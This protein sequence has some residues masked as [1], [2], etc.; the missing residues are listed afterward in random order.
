MLE[1]AA[2]GTIVVAAQKAL[3]IVCGDTN[4]HTQ[5]CNDTECHPST[6]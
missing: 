6:D 4:H 5:I 1:G 3:E 2:A